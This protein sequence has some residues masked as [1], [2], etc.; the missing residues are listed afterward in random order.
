MMHE[1][2]HGSLFCAMKSLSFILAHCS[3]SWSLFPLSLL[4]VLYHEVTFLYLGSL[5]CAMKS[6]FFILA[7]CS[8]P[9]SYF[10]LSIVKHCIITG[11]GNWG[12]SPTI[13]LGYLTSEMQRRKLLLGGLK[14]VVNEGNEELCNSEIMFEIDVI[15]KSIDLCVNTYIHIYIHTY[16]DI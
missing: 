4:I 7:H 5:F 14:H 12:N 9:W 10:P 13:Q 15:L 11:W 3:L 1:N 16:V 2:F 8:L 6:L